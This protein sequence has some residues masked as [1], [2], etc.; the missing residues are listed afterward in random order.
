MLTK[1]RLFMTDMYCVQATD[2]YK[3]MQEDHVFYTAAYPRGVNSDVN[4]KV[5]REFK[6]VTC[7]RP[8]RGFRAKCYSILLPKKSEEM[9][10]E[11][12]HAMSI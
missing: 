2:L 3:D 5:V 11:V 1:L 10:T 8:V 7:G 12:V 6:D 9:V 4:K